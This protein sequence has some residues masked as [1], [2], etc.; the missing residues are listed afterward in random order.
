M[1]HDAGLRAKST[2][3]NAIAAPSVLITFIA[4]RAALGVVVLLAFSFGTYWF[5][6]QNFY[7]AAYQR[8]LVPLWWDWLKGMPSGRSLRVEAFGFDQPQLVPALGHTMVLIAVTFLLVVASSLLLGLLAAVRAGSAVDGALRIFFY[9]AWSVPAFLLALI[10]QTF[11]LWLGKPLPTVGFAGFCPSAIVGGFNN[12]PCPTGHGLYYALNVLRHIALPAAALSVNF[13][14][15]HARYLRS[16][17]VVALDEPYAM[18]ARAKGLP[19]RAV[20]LRHALRNSLVAFSSALLLDFGALFGAALAIDWVFKIG[21]I[22][23]LFLSLIANPS[24]DPNAVTSVL[25]VTALLVL[26]ASLANDLVVPLLDP[27]ARA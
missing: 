27:R 5:F 20:V 23:S 9:A 18:T 26:L 4:R 12:G 16:S 8:P 1:A 10:V 15:L 7:G 22:G 14:G 19:E 25:F 21:G 11:V 2:G 17:L 6:G 3:S 24:I 13:I